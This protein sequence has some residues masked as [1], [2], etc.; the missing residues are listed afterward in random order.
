VSL[1]PLRAAGFVVHEDHLRVSSAAFLD[2]VRA[3]FAR[4]HGVTRDEVQVEFRIIRPAPKS[5]HSG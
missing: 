1:Y 3:E 4:L 5:S 2:R